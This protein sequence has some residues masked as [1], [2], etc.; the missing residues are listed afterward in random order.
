M[1]TSKQQHKHKEPTHNAGSTRAAAPSLLPKTAGSQWVR[2]PRL[3][4]TPA[5]DAAIC[6]GAP[7][8]A[9]PA[10]APSRRCCSAM[11]LHHTGS[12]SSCHGAAR[13]EGAAATGKAAGASHMRRIVLRL[14]WCLCSALVPPG[15]ACAA[16]QLARWRRAAAALTAA[17]RW[18][19]QRCTRWR[20]G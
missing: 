19:W 7:A 1:D 20:L 8:C 4:L 14:G 15:A 6:I 17:R 3:P 11:Q 18:Q 9:M 5:Y 2:R 13:N 16:A 12:Q 10:P